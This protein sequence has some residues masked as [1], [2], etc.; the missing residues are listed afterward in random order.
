VYEKQFARFREVPDA[1]AS[2]LAIGEAPAD[3]SF[4]KAELAAWAMVA[5]VILNTDE[6][7]TKG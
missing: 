1:A 3:A 6:A 4:E 5:S 2:L 7:V